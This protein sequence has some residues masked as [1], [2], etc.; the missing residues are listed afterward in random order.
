MIIV[1]DGDADWCN[2]KTVE[3]DENEFN[4]NKTILTDKSIDNWNNNVFVVDPK[5]KFQQKMDNSRDTMNNIALQ[6]FRKATGSKVFGFFILANTHGNIRSA[7]RN[8]YCSAEGEKIEE[9]YQKNYENGELITK[10]ITK[11]I[12][13]EKYLISYKSGFDA[14][15]LI[16]GGDELKTEDDEIE[17]DGKITSSKLTKA[18]MKMN[19]KK[20]INRV[21]VSKFIQG[22]A[23]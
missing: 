20:Q 12:R 21:L 13:D 23:A 1:H 8:H 11:Q 17:I 18:F 10:K 3:M 9:I 4:Q 6:Y 5:I 16:S 7:I 15:Y 22:I 14:F 19:K 2:R